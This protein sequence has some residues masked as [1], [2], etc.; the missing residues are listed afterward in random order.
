MLKSSIK[1]SELKLKVIK[2][3]HKVPGLWFYKSADRF[4]SGIPDLLICWNGKFC[5][6]EL[7]TTKGRVTKLQEHVL[8]SIETC[9][10]ITYVIRSMDDLSEFLKHE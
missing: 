9:G 7:K 5:A 4:T 10:G 1:E 6:L 8:R 3:L 2:R